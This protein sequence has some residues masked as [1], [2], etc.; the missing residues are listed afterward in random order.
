MLNKANTRST[1]TRTHMNHFLNL[2]D[3]TPL[4]W[5]TQGLTQLNAGLLILG[6]AGLLLGIMFTS[7]SEDP[8]DMF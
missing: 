2:A 1:K 3:I 7:E 5:A 4:A 8:S 6:F